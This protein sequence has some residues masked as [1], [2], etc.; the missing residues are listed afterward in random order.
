MT[1]P[2]EQVLQDTL[3]RAVDGNV[4]VPASR[5]SCD[6]HNSVSHNSLCNTLHG[7]VHGTAHDNS[8]ATV[9]ATV[10]ETVKDCA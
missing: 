3:F 9:D 7:A 5:T 1:A 8:H 4:H 6:Q 10:N 2:L